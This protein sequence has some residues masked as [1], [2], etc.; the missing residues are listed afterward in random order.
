[1]IQR[2]IDIPAGDP[3]VKN[4][5]TIVFDDGIQLLSVRPHMHKR[6]KHVRYDIVY[7]DGKSEVLLSIPRWDFNWQSI[8]EFAKPVTIPPGAGIKMTIFWDNSALNPNNPVNPPEDI[9]WGLQTN[10]EMMNG[11]LTYI[12]LKEE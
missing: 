1:M 6:G 10:F 3:L 8:Y 5:K 12:P 4:E 9:G 11:G 7:A 2:K